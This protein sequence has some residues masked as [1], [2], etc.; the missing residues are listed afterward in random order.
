MTSKAYSQ[1]TFLNPDKTDNEELLQ[2]EKQ[3][4]KATVYDAVAGK[5][6]LFITI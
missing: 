2:E 5:P 3:I 4:R 6:S 1:N